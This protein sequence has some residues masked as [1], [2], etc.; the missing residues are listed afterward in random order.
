[1]PL[2]ESILKYEAE[3]IIAIINTSPIM[4]QTSA[5]SDGRDIGGDLAICKII[6]EAASSFD[7]VKDEDLDSILNKVDDVTKQIGFRH[8]GNKVKAAFKEYIK[9]KIEFYQRLLKHKGETDNYK[10]AIKREFNNEE[11]YRNAIEHI[12]EADTK[13]RNIM[14]EQLKHFMPEEARDEVDIA[15]D[16]IRKTIEIIDEKIIAYLFKS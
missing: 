12:K 6:L 8:K 13:Y 9:A 5:L 3:R 7:N 4:K 11:N 15:F 10:D 2:E 16:Y 1:M 14:A